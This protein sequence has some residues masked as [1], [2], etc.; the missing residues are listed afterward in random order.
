MNPMSRREAAKAL[1]GLGLLRLR[2]AGTG[3]RSYVFFGE[4][5]ERISEKSFLD[6]EFFEGAQIRYSWRQIEPGLDRY[7]FGDIEHDV[8]F[9]ESQG[10]RLFVQIQDISY[11]P[12]II[13]LP[14]Y[15]LMNPAFHGGRGA[16]IRHTRRRREACNSGRM[17]GIALGPSCSGAAL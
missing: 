3:F 12:S 15:L 6:A 1:L 2:G 13:P 16:A 11:S 8:T 9:L 7:D 17:G 5:R 10:K 4:D 14:R